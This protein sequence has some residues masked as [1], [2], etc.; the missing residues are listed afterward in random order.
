MKNK[1]FKQALSM[2]LCAVMIFCAAPLAGL[3]ELDPPGTTT[4]EAAKATSGVYTYT[5]SN[6]EA[7]ITDVDGSINGDI[8]VPATL[9]GYIVTSIGEDAF[10]YRSN[11][12]SIKITSSYISSIGDYAFAHCEGLESV[13]LSAAVNSIGDYAFYDC[14]KLKSL[15]VD[16][17]NKWFYSDAQGVLFN[18]EKTEL[19]KYPSGL[20]ATSYTIPNGV[21]TI[22]CDSFACS[23]NLKTVLFADTVKHI[24]DD[25]FRYCLNLKSIDIPSGTKSIGYRAFYTCESLANITIP[26]SV[27]YIDDAAF[28][29]TL[30][31]D[32]D[33]NWKDG[34]LRIGN[35]IIRVKENFEGPFTVEN[36]VKTI[37]CDAFFDCTRIISVT[38]PKSVL[39][40]GD[41]V[42]F[43]CTGIGWFNVDSNNPNYSSDE[44]GV[45]FN[46]AKTELLQY[47]L[48]NSRKSY[49]VPDSVTIIDSYS[50]ADSK[51]LE[52]ILFGTGTQLKII[53]DGAFECTV[54]LKSMVIP[55][56]VV[57]LGD[58][59]FSDSAELISVTIPYGVTSIS[60]EMFYYCQ[61]LESVTIPNSVT[62]I[63]DSAFYE[64]ES[65]E[66]ITIPN[67][68]TSI[69]DS[70][71]EVC[72]NLDN[73]TI[74]KSVKII[75]DCAFYECESLRNIVIP[76]SVTHIGYATFYG[77]TSL[78]NATLN[79]GL[80]SIGDDTFG[81]CKKL[82]IVTIPESVTSIGIAAFDN[83]I[84]LD[85]VTIPNSV[86]SIGDYAFYKCESL[87]N[88]VI[89]NSVTLIGKCA[90]HSCTSLKNA[91]IHNGPTS[92]DDFAF[93][94]C[95][96]LK[97]ITIAK[98]VTSIGLEAF[99]NCTSLTDVY[100]SGTDAEWAAI[101]DGGNNGCL[102]NA[103]IHTNQTITPLPPVEPP[104]PTEPAFKFEIENPSTT[105]I[106]Y[107][108]SIKL[109]ASFNGTL[110]TGAKIVWTSDNK[111]FS[112][113]VKDNGAICEITPSASGDT[114]FTAT[115]CDK[116]GNVIDSD[117]QKMT[118]KAGFFDKIIAFFKKLFGLNKNYEKAIK[119]I[120]K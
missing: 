84:N 4:A 60:E 18:K 65:L 44:N 119:I 73:V 85:D 101:S 115:L 28:E 29:Y 114:T 42:F 41:T 79:Y 113:D 89:P 116:D 39:N 24:S 92:I 27:T 9:G 45:L 36:G 47:P 30:Y 46:K 21:M 109:H 10:S 14:K 69:G 76:G 96:N 61:K 54:S 3:I 2:L 15:S 57:T 66:S 59:L 72:I 58:Y 16:A 56:G 104:K 102:F 51:F 34:V 86:K 95:S 25:S 103:T 81:Y 105:T 7:T 74:P 71:F 100:Y 48:G 33:S 99:L 110:P 53:G 97:K 68:V 20:P 118:S 83:C 62:S 13:T 111:N 35:H 26:D 8:T 32:T 1:T 94:H 22:G 108:D 88:I 75:G 64:C 80:T 107:G 37:A 23:N 43:C 50:F 52:T 11:I 70:A 31:F 17:N 12:K 98:S 87:R 67:S 117:T 38:I 91:T 106:S 93:A 112:Y 6:N 78:K 5:V 55:D 120:L 82:E 77:C 90:F 40:I 19:L 49:T 63:G